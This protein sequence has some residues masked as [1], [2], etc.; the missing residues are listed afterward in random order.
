MYEPGT[1][2]GAYLRE[3][4]REFRSVEVDSTFYGIPTPQRLRRWAQA[5]PADFTFA[6]KLP[7]VITHER[8]LV[9]AEKLVAEFFASAL[10][11]GSQLEAV[12]VQLPP[13][14][15]PESWDALAAFV[16]GLDYAA[17]IAIELRDPRWFEIERCAELRA[18]LSDR[19][20]ALAVSDGTFVELNVMLAAFVQPTA[21]FGYIRWLGRRAS[22][23]RFDR[24]SIDRTANIVRWTAVLEAAGTRLERVCGYANN[25]YMG[26]GPATVRALYRQ[27]GILHGRPARFVQTEL[28]P[29]GV[30]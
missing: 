16:R 9:G 27:L 30:S 21:R 15:G 28:F 22:V 18:L 13:D 2:P 3:Y 23:A 1:P 8:R 5:V 19:G 4:S 11:L 29:N 24:V 6:L 25:H 10:T 20:I 26:H 12:L 14:F 7:R 17:R